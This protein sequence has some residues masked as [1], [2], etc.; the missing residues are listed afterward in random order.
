MDHKKRIRQ[1]RK[2]VLRNRKRKRK[3]RQL[4]RRKMEVERVRGKKLMIYLIIQPK[5]KMNK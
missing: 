3:M 2:K 4:I 5:K 1:K